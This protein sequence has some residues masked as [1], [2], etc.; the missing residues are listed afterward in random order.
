MKPLVDR[1][2][3][4]PIA[5]RMRGVLRG[6]SDDA[7]LELLAQAIADEIWASL[8]EEGHSAGASGGQRDANAP[9]QVNVPHGRTSLRGVRKRG[10]PEFAR[11]ANV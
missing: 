1:E 7:A 5:E 11:S 9:G 8:V 2:Q 4:A 3:D 10:R 6:L